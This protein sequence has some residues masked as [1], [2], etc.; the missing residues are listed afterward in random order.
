MNINIHMEYFKSID[1]PELDIVVNE[2]LIE[3][4]TGDKTE[5]CT[6]DYQESI[7]K[8]PSLIKWAESISKI[9]LHKFGT[10]KIF[11]T[12]ANSSGLLHLDYHSTSRVAINIPILNCQGT[13]FDYYET[14]DTNLTENIGEASN[15]YGLSFKP[16]DFSLLRNA[17]SLELTSPHLIRTDRLHRAVNY[18]TTARIVATLRW[19]PNRHL[20][21]F[22]DFINVIL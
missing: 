14:P 21:E 7:A 15:G 1:I 16:K 17:K 20:T 8:F 3:S 6:F 13:Q 2:L 12:A 18:T 19:E 9:P 4:P 22:A 5:S 11:A 10:I